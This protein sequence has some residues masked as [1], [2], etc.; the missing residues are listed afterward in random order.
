[1]DAGIHL[2][3]SGVIGEGNKPVI[4]TTPI[5][6][7]YH[8]NIVPKTSRDGSGRVIRWTLAR[9]LVFSGI[10]VGTMSQNPTLGGGGLI[11]LYFIPLILPED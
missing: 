11:W 2:Q 9:L 1:L 6:I 4:T 10:A 5:R 8:Q 7:S 3:I